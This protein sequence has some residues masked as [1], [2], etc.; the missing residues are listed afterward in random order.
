MIPVLMNDNVGQGPLLQSIEWHHSIIDGISRQST[1]AVRDMQNT[2]VTHVLARD[3]LSHH[4]D[5]QWNTT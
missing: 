4:Q 3:T 5:H 2:L 1:G